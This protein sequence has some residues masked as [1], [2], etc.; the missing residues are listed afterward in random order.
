MNPLSRIRAPADQ[1][2]QNGYTRTLEALRHEER[3]LA[4]SLPLL[5]LAVLVLFIPA[6]GGLGSPP[7]RPLLT[8][9]NLTGILLT[10]LTLWLARN[11]LERIRARVEACREMETRL[12]LPALQESSVLDTHPLNLLFSALI[13]LLLGGWILHLILVW[14]L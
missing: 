7:L 11:L 4:V 1:P 14:S 13:I 9:I 3:L 6:A 2:L 12:C 10:L 5:L 8:A